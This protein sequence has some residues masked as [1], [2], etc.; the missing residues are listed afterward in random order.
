[1]KQVINRHLAILLAT[2]FNNAGW[3]LDADGKIEMKDGNPVYVDSSGRELTVDQ[4]T[5]TRL[6]GEAKT[7][8]EAKEAAEAKLAAFKD[9]DPVKAKDAMEKLSQI[10]QSKLI[11]NGKLEEVK[12]QITQQFTTQLTEKDNALKSLQSQYDNAQI[13]NIFANSEFIRE[14]IAVPRDMF[15]ATFKNNFIIEDGKIVV[16]DKAGNRI[17]S[18]TK[19]GEYADPSEALELLVESHPQKDVI[20]KASDSNGT[21]S[22]GNGGNRGRGTTIKRAEWEKYNPAQQAEAAG[23]MR[24]GELQ[25]VD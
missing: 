22:N 3:K 21:G 6:N 9:I 8:R 12:Q 23:K 4:G 14:R 18:K 1:M 13:S 25:I 24:S 10:D 16:K 11:D 20:L 2:A 5:I 7:H 15:E 17:M 19:I